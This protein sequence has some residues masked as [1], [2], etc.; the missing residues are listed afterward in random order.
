MI[1]PRSNGRTQIVPKWP[2]LCFGA[3]DRARRASA[4][5]GCSRGCVGS[6]RN[7]GLPISPI[8]I[9][10]SPTRPTRRHSRRRKRSLFSE[11]ASGGRVGDVALP[12]SLGSRRP[13]CGSRTRR[14]STRRTSRSVTTRSRATYRWTRRVACDADPPGVAHAGSTRGAAKSTRGRRGH[15][16][17]RSC[18]LGRR[19]SGS[20]ARRIGM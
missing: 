8:T 16:D 13:R 4:R 1:D 15:R 11:E 20:A 17:E 14:R 9:A 10:T 12:S 5:W 19:G 6:G 3:F 18:A 7:A 2:K